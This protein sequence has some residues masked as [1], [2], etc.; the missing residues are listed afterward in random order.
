MDNGLAATV[1][2]PIFLRKPA[3]DNPTDPTARFAIIGGPLGVLEY[4][5]RKKKARQE[6][7]GAQ[8]HQVCVGKTTVARWRAGERGGYKGERCDLKCNHSTSP[9]LLEISISFYLSDY[10]NCLDQSHWL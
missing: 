8:G 10:L 2:A 1:N 5:G 7:E 9:L 6:E 3:V 4:A